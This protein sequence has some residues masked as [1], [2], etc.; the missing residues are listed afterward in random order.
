MEKKRMTITLAGQE[1]RISSGNGEEQVERLAA[2][3]NRRIR[4]AMAQYP[5]QSTSRCALLAM[6]SM[7][8]ELESLRAESAEVDRKIGELRTLRESHDSRV[9]APVKRPFERKKPVGV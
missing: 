7:E 1:F 2:S 6:L 3:V 4:E 9:S 8:S 5:D